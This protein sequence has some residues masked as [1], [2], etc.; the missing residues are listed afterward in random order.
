MRPRRRSNSRLLRCGGEEEAAPDADEPEAGPEAVYDGA[1]IDL[2]ST[3]GEGGGADMQGRA[4]QS[5]LTRHIPGL[6]EVTFTP[7]PG[8]GQTV[9]NAYF[10]ENAEKDG[11]E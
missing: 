9:G 4:V 3:F 8:G 6:G 1:T 5:A 7:R 2:H 11:T 10:W